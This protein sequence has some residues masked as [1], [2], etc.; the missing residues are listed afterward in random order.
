M[1]KKRTQ[2]VE[3]TTDGGRRRQ[4][5]LK[6]GYGVLGLDRRRDRTPRRRRTT[7]CVESRHRRRSHTHSRAGAWTASCRRKA[8]RDGACAAGCRRGCHRRVDWP[9]APRNLWFS[10]GEELP[11]K[12][13]A[14][15]AT[16][17]RSGGGE[18]DQNETRSLE[19]KIRFS[20]LALIPCE[21][22]KIENP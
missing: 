1:K 9:R 8:A 17:R 12:S 3:N 2:T 22:R 11:G 15:A 10:A 7:L 5:G 14:A 21:E 18:G 13:P 20:S 6:G 4:K 16:R 19:K